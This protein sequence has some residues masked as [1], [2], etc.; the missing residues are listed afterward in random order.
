MAQAG[1]WEGELEELEGQVSACLEARQK[2]IL[3]LA[4]ELISL[5][6]S[7]PPGDE[8]AV[9]NL[10]CQA[11]ADQGFE[12]IRQVCRRPERP[13]VIAGLGRGRP[14]LVLTGHMDTKPPGALSE[15]EF[16][17]YE[18]VVRDDF[19]Y[20]L[21]SADMKAA[22]AAMV[23]AAGAL[24]RCD[25]PA[26]RLALVFTADEEAGSACGTRYLLSSEA[27]QADAAVVGEPCGIGRSWEF[28]AVA[29][30]GISC[31]RV[32]VGGTQVHSA[33]SDRLPVVN[34][35]V[36][37]AEVLSRFSR[38]FRLSPAP[39][40][41]TYGGATVNAGVT[42]SGGAGFGIYPG[43]AEFGVDVRTVPG[44]SLAQLQ[45]DVSGFLER[46]RC[47]DADLDVSSM[48]MP[49]LEWIAPSA[50]DPEHGL[51]QAARWASRKV[52]GKEMPPGLM[53]ATT[54][55]TFWSLAGVPCIPALGPGLLSV[56]HRPNERVP[57]NDLLASGRI[58]ALTAL[59]YLFLH[60]LEDDSG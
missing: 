12:E 44:M 57:V 46:Q 38:E 22:M 19:L 42:L 5:P 34:A 10:L 49:G 28:I 25:L 4:R 54:D 31:F 1:R 14:I 13:N 7:N 53:P 17:P 37:M 16:L 58:Y 15:W 30:R 51:V 43:W 21:G 11:L 50:I 52:F 55:G 45:A 47:L 48:W 59:R 40:G 27:V 20:G 18:P 3:G 41:Q 32:R 6:S 9:A 36:R 23:F 29:S 60:A 39:S 8:R 35:S 26:G 2:E 24:A 56:A 33:L